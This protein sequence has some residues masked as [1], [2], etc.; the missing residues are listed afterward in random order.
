MQPIAKKN[1]E[2]FGTFYEK[3]DEVNVENKEMLI[4][5]VERGFIEPLTPKQI[6]EYGKKP[7]LKKLIKEED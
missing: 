7:V 4:K 3:G 6:Q 5:L 1:F 2:L